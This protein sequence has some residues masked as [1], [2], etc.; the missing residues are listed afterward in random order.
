MAA[1]GLP[2][3]SAL[4]AVLLSLSPPGG[5]TKEMVMTPMSTPATL[6]IVLAAEEYLPGREIIATIRLR[7]TADRPLWMNR[8]MLL[9]SRHAPAPFRELTLDIRGPGGRAVDF[10]CKVRAGP[11][12][13]KNYALVPARSTIE[14]RVDLTGCFDLSAAGA[15]QLVA[16]YRD[17][18][19]TPPAPPGGSVPLVGEVVSD[20]ARI[21]ILANR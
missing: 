10:N 1:D 17:G 6:E 21:E 3:I 16:H 18:N 19:E 20:P 15:Y 2:H 4:F 12:Q 9:N 11:P 14:Q 7:N 13:P 8:R 5:G